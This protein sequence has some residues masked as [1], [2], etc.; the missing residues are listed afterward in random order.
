[1]ENKIAHILI[2]KVIDLHADYKKITLTDDKLECIIENDLDINDIDTNDTNDQPEWLF[3]LNFKSGQCND[4]TL[5]LEDVDKIMAFTNRPYRL[6]DI[7]ETDEFT[8]F[9]DS[10][11]MDN[12]SYN[13]P[14]AA[15]YIDNKIIIVKLLSCVYHNNKFIFKYEYLDNNSD[16][17][18]KNFANGSLFVDPTCKREAKS[19]RSMSRESRRPMNRSIIVRRSRGRRRPAIKK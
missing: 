1:M 14:N 6:S 16:V 17:I 19:R 5:V 7:I 10:N 18:P 2:N 4:N 11:N 3:A 13:P 9:W 8:E 15:L 12:F